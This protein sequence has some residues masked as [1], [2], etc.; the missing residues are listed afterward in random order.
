MR[1]KTYKEFINQMTWWK[2]DEWDKPITGSKDPEYNRKRRWHTGYISYGSMGRKFDIISEY[3]NK[4][5]SHIFKIFGDDL[6][7]S[8]LESAKAFSLKEL[9]K[10]VIGFVKQYKNF[11]EWR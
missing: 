9:H 11:Q 8:S 4:D 5:N 7:F 1:K 10:I 3:I 2:V 6:E